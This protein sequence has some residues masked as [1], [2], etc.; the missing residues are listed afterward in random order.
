[1]HSDVK[2]DQHIN[3]YYRYIKSRKLLGG[4]KHLMYDALKEANKLLAYTSLCR[5]M[6]LSMRMWCG[7]LWLEMRFMT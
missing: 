5:P 7:T 3:S 6:Y 4:I 2:F 1:M